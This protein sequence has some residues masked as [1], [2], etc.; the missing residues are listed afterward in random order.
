M[1]WLKKQTQHVKEKIAKQQ[2][3]SKIK[4]QTFQGAGHSLQDSSLVPPATAPP[5]PVHVKKS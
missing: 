4:K 5:A 1:D 2:Q 3:E